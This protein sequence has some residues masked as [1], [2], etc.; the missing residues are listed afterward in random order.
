MKRMLG[1]QDKAP[2]CPSLVVRGSHENRRRVGPF[3]KTGSER[4]KGDLK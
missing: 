4:M 2:S 1:F 3:S